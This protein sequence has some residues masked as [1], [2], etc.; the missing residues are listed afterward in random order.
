MP[1]TDVRHYFWWHLTVRRTPL[2]PCADAGRLRTAAM[3]K[4]CV[5]PTHSRHFA[6]DPLERAAPD[7][8]QFL[9]TR[10]ARSGSTTI[11]LLVPPVLL[12][13]PCCRTLQ[14]GSHHADSTCMPF[15]MLCDLDSTI[16]STYYFLCHAHIAHSSPL[17]SEAL[18]ID[19]H[20]R[21]LQ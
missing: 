8:E 10:T 19:S 1:T 20:D 12:F 21:D 6:D 2:C 17:G 9:S 3:G 5:R 13:I 15:R 14:A 11:A 16:M 4:N 18:C 7:P